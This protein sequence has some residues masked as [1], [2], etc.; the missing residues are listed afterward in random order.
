M[1]KP[2]R[3]G[4]LPLHDYDAALRNAVSWLGDNYLLAVPA[5]RRDESR[6]PYFNA[7]RP[8][9]GAARTPIRTRH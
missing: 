1:R 6:K 4:A 8:W 9:I 2:D 3:P 7:P 5:P